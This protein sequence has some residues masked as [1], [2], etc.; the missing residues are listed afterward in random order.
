MMM[1]TTNVLDY[2]LMIFYWSER[3]ILLH[4]RWHPRNLG[5]LFFCQLEVH[6]R[7]HE[8]ASQAQERHGTKQ[9]EQAAT[10]PHSSAQPRGTLQS[11]C[12]AL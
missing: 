12:S 5:F 2:V 1:Y 9:Q 10:S 11:P 4:P 8:A 3:I 6:A 7:D